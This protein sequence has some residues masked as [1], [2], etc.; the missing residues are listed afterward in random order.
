MSLR[1]DFRR[2]LRAATAWLK[3]DTKRRREQ[4]TATQP[5]HKM[6]DGGKGADALDKALDEFKKDPVLGA[7]DTTPTRSYAGFGER[8][9]A[10][11]VAKPE[12][13]TEPG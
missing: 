1:R 5:E 9:V 10:G 13:S 8:D 4:H 6:S 7:L 3:A 12:P 2:L 11:P